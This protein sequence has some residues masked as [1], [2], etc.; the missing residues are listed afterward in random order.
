M[1][2][3]EGLLGPQG[4]RRLN[5]RLI[6]ARLACVVDMDASAVIV[7]RGLSKLPIDAR[8]ADRAAHAG[9]EPEKG[10]SA[11]R[12]ACRAVVML[13]EGRLAP[14][15]TVIVGVFEV[16]ENRNGVPGLAEL[17]IQCLRVSHLRTIQQRQHTASVEVATVTADATL[18]VHSDVACKASRSLG[19]SLSVRMAREA[20]LPVRPKPQAR[21]VCGGTDASVYGERGIETVV[22]STGTRR[23]RS[24][25]DHIW[26]EDMAAAARDIRK[27]LEQGCCEFPPND[28]VRTREE[29]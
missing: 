22:T 3:R 4:V 6:N 12:V 21:L 8:A 24:T 10:I 9:I 29:K 5:M 2:T 23:K 18:E 11:I 20:M 14:E 27:A 16:S 28:Q 1:I 26:V 25:K 15:M 17:K 19:D 7:I 13:K